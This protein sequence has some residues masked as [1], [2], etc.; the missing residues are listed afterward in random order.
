MLKVGRTVYVGR[1]ARTNEHGITQL[2]AI[3]EPLGYRVRPVPVTKVLHLKS[4]VTALPDGT[5][6]GWPRRS[7]IPARSTP[8][9]PCRRRRARPSWWST[10]AP[11]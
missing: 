8:S 4:A 11:C 9:S 6:I 2:A 10:T 5:V 3:I 7:T 1:S